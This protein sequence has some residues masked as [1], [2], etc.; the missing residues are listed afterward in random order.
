MSQRVS[1]IIAEVTGVKFREISPFKR[2]LKK[3]GAK[4]TSSINR[5]AWYYPLLAKVFHKLAD[6]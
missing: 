3:L 4:Y 2:Y 6:K 5:K 1:E